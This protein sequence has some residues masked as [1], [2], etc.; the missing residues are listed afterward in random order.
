MGLEKELTD[1]ERKLWT[2]NAAFY[3]NSLVEDALLIFP[4]TGPISRDVAVD[5]ILTENAEGQKWTEVEFHEVRSLALADDVA[6]LTYRVAA[7]WEHETSKNS[8]L[9]SSVYI[10]RG[11]VWKLALHQQ[12]PI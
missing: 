12:T 9:A 11:G 1:I 5:A 8:A 6:L 10:K 7:R 2:N 4:E 3:K